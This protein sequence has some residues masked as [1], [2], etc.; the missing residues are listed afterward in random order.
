M[1]R[2]PLWLALSLLVLTPVTAGVKQEEP[3][4]QFLVV[5]CLLPGKIRR[6][7][8]ITTYITPRRPVR[9]TAEN[10]QIRGGEY[11]SYDRANYNTAL[12]VWLAKAEEGDK[13]A[14]YYVGQIYERG[15][16]RE[17]DYAQAATWY[18]RAAEQGFARAQVSLASLY[19]TGQGVAQDPSRA[20]QLYGQAAGMP[21]SP[22]ILDPE[23]VA[24]TR[25]ELDGARRQ[26]QQYKQEIAAL[27]ARLA[28]L[29]DETAF[30]KGALAE[31]EAELGENRRRYQRAQAR[32]EQLSAGGASQGAA[33]AAAQ[34][35][36][37]ALRESIKA[38]ESEI[39]V[40]RSNL[41]RVES[42]RERFERKSRLA[43][44]SGEASAKSLQ[45][46]LKVAQKQ[47]KAAKEDAARYQSHAVSVETRLE[48]AQKELA[49]LK[50]AGSEQSGELTTLAQQ[51][52]E[53]EE[54][55]RTNQQVMQNLQN[56]MER[57]R[58]EAEQYQRQ[59]AASQKPAAGSDTTLAE[60]AGPTIEIIDPA[61]TV[62]RGS[63][64][65]VK[66]RSVVDS[67]RIIGRASAPSGI[68]SV[69]VNDRGVDPNKYGIFETEVVV[70]GAQTPVKVVA[71]DELGKRAMLEFQ[72]QLDREKFNLVEGYPKSKPNELA[73]PDVEFGSYHALLIGNNEYQHLP[74]LETAINDVEVLE[75]LLRK[76][77]GFQTT[78]VRNATRYDILS[79]LNA[80]REKLTEEDNLL[81]YYAGHGI[82]DE[83][84]MRGQWLPV[85]AEP[86]SSA[87]WISNVAVTDILNIIAAKQVLLVVDS[88]YSGALTRSA[89]TKLETGKT[90]RQRI[91]W[92]KAMLEKR[93]RT[94]LTS[95]G[96]KPVLDAGG[97]DHSVF[98]KA[99]IEVLRENEGLLEGGRLYKEVSA[100]VA[101]AA[102]RIRFKQLP[103]YAPIKHA[104]HEA[105]DFF[106]VPKLGS[107][108]DTAAT[109]E[110]P[111][112]LPLSL[113]RL[114]P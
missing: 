94:V 66:L 55:K 92:V 43:A 53:L 22:V 21:G 110:A 13:L 2:I 68:E 79:A 41:A 6:L 61:L 5:D 103:E 40:L 28:R 113:A 67:R 7:G 112:I 70:L 71:V 63:M 56:E 80:L 105:G 101:Y 15:L 62:T 8:S 27:R 54:E 74:K 108:G 107:V 86:D 23:T 98:A 57:L 93:S 102:S 89:L 44:E 46:E 16:G 95:G 36:L 14:Q 106:L 29:E 82:L 109:M 48:Q 50:Q 76:K 17:P 99:L 96:L 32:L 38:H 88:C 20:A 77:Y 78:V 25:A 9:T 114:L 31:A 1:N 69:T 85:D 35:E 72:M 59:L 87:N 52:Q 90:D 45:T 42:E 26:I 10:C 11:T 64:P 18:G 37:D 4:E 65:L 84:N 83:V 30:Y 51:V 111:S 100:R 81:I 12:Q 19:E 33:Q 47:L 24:A 91:N 73:I 97:G 39:E 3:A 58:Q 75:E 49:G 60:L 104:G 34:K